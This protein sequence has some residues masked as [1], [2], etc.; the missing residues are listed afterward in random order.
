VDAGIGVQTP[1]TPLGSNFYMYF[2]GPDKEVVEVYTGSKNH[3]YEHVHLLA[4]DV[5]ATV[6][7]FLD[8]LALTTRRP[9]VPRR[10]SGT[11]MN[12][13][14][15]DN[16]N[17]IVFGVPAPGEARPGWYPE[18]MAD[19]FTPTEGTAIDH[20]GFS[21]EDIQPVFDRMVEAGVEIVAPIASTEYGLTSFFVRGPDKLLVEIVQEKPVPAGIWK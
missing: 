4:T 2:W 12:T 15:I 6:G 1:I 19:E 14:R 11:W 9:Q 16:V 20:I 13:I 18:A 17:L 8:N 7:W 21:F 3:R 10:F 5:N